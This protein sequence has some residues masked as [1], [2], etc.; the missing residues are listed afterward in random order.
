MNFTKF[1]ILITVFF[2]LTA[3]SQRTTGYSAAIPAEV[4]ANWRLADVVVVV[5][6]GL[7]TTEQNSLAPEADIVW[8]GDPINGGTRQQQV[9][10]ILRN[11]IIDGGSGLP[12]S[13]PVIFVATL[14]QFHAITPRA[15]RN[16]GGIHNVD[17]N[18][19]VID[20]KN[21]QPLMEPVFIEA[22]EFAFAGA[23]AAAA[24]ASGQT[25]KVRIRNRIRLVIASWLSLASAEEQVTL[26]G[27]SHIGR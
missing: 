17:F 11:G 9:A 21:G 14:V 15:R 27:V 5:P 8:H 22:D 4:R 23:E 6:E 18:I 24:E 1:L 13:Q 7:T 19:S 3:C 16:V 12:G 20:A 26:G 25:Q 2:G 10:E